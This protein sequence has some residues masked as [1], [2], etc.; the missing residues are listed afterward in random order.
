MDFSKCHSRRCHIIVTLCC[1]LDPFGKLFGLDGTILFAFILGFP[2]N[3][4]V[5]PIMIMTYMATGTLTEIDDLMAL[6]E[7]L[8]ANN[9]TWVTALCVIVFSLVHW[10]SSTTCLSIKKK[11]KVGNGLQ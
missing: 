6:K 10:P 5:V 3:E 9:W 11:Q 8:V 4:I 2:A 7:L 1:F